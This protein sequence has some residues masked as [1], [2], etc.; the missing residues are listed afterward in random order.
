MR[1]NGRL[2]FLLYIAAVHGEILKQKNK[3]GSIRRN[4]RHAEQ[5]RESHGACS[6]YMTLRA[7]VTMGP[8]TVTPAARDITLAVTLT[9]EVLPA[10]STCT[11]GVTERGALE[12]AQ[13]YVVWASSN[14]TIKFSG[15]KLCNKLPVH[16]KKWTKNKKKFKKALLHYLHSHSFYSTKEFFYK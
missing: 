16:I 8:V 11:A 10:R 2:K 13:K 14:Q 4:R 9:R 12:L 15:I 3:K 5:E 7:S 6:E 1:V